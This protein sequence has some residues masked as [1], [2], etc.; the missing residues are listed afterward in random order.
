MLVDDM[1][2]VINK[3]K[4]AGVDVSATIYEGMSHDFQLLLTDL[5]ESKAAWAEMG[6]FIKDLFEGQ[7]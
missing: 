2:T 3:A 7:Q 1:V 6:E 4:E 5:E